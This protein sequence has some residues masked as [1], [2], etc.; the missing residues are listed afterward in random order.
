MA[1]TASI[2]PIDRM[3]VVAG[4]FFAAVGVIYG[5]VAV[6]TLPMRTALNIGYGY[7]P[8]ILLGIL[9]YCNW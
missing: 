2:S 5:G 1:R 3:S 7:F 6:T 8:I 9:F 4:A